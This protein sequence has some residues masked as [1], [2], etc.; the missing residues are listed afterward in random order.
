MQFRLPSWD[1]LQ[2]QAFLW[3][4]IAFI[5]FTVFHCEKIA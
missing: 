5:L 2:L 3:E 4:K 1:E